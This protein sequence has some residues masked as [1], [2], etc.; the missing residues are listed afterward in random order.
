MEVF[1]QFSEIEEGQWFVIKRSNQICVKNSANTAR[2]WLGR[3][4]EIFSVEP[5]E[6][7]YIPDDEERLKRTGRW[8]GSW[9]PY[10]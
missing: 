4:R 8:G 2:E 10:N 7:V 6:Q 5:T 1:M 9:K 3:Y